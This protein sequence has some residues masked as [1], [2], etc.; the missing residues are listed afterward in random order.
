ME[1]E[2]I[3]TRD[4]EPDIVDQSLLQLVLNDGNVTK[5]CRDMKAAG[6]DIPRKTLTGW[7]DAYPRRYQFHAT[8]SARELEERIVTKQRA[9]A[10]A[11]LD[12][13]QEAIEKEADRVKAGDVRD[14]AASARSLATTS[15]IATDKL[16][17]MTGRP[18][19]IVQHE[20]KPEQIIAKL[21]E[22]GVVEGT[23]EEVDDEATA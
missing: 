9:I 23:A 12:V 11:A 13:V 22:L 2:P 20:R 16:L 17:A 21:Q 18:S 6:V 10:S 8:Q 7:R 4:Y 14:M 19:A 1:L 3:K 5:T 15:A